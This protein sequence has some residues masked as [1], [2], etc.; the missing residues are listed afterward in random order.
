L[1]HFVF[2]V[3]GT[4]VAKQYKQSKAGIIYSKGRVHTWEKTVAQFAMAEMQAGWKPCIGTIYLHL[5]FKFAVPKTR[6]DVMP[7]DPHLQDPDLTNL[8]KAAED[9]LKRVIFAD[10][11]MV[12]SISGSKTWCMPGDE[13]VKVE[14][15]I[16]DD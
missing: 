16:Y 8:I 12:Q 2:F 3:P 6:K 4:P 7:G 14:M 13:G 5:Y 9:G 10:D 11:N 15:E 1:K